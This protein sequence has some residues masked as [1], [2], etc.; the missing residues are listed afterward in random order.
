MT[1]ADPGFCDDCGWPIVACVCDEVDELDDDDLSVC[2]H[3]FGFDEDCEE[4][5]ETT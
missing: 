3:G 2:K 5:D 1:G 4:C